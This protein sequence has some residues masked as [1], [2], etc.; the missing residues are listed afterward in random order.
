MTLW[1]PEVIP[2]SVATTLAD[3]GRLELVA[4]F[5]LA[6]GTGL[7]LHFGHR[8]SADLDLFTAGSSR[9]QRW[10]EALSSQ[11]AGFSLV[12]IAPETLHF[13]QGATKV[14]LGYHYP[15]AFPAESYSG[16]KVAE[17]RDIACMKLSAVASRGTR[18][19][20]VDLYFAGQKYGLGDLLEIFQRK[21]AQVRYP[22]VHLL[23]S[24]TY[25]VDAEKDPMPDMLVGVD[26]KEI[27]A[28]FV[29]EASKLV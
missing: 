12:G 6:G 4:E 5:Y 10:L 18:R 7:A 29:R 17:P 2:E 9:E 14:R 3:L 16:V 22:H 25:F 1:H 8:R 21:Y 28:Y 26:W 15:L 19:D 27:R 20:F 11:L 23:K 13:R 24:L